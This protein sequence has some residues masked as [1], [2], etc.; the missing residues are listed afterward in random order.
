MNK[1]AERSLVIDSTNEASE[2]VILSDS[3][4][5]TVGGGLANS[6]IEEDPRDGNG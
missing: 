2:V 6:G 4:M 3:D 5:E 1:T